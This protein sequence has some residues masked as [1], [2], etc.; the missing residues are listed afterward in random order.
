MKMR[1]LVAL[2]LAV[3]TLTTMS[4][5]GCSKGGSSSGA[6]K[7]VQTI[8]VLKPDDSVTNATYKKFMPNL[9]RN[10]QANI[11]QY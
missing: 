4:L 6:A 5:T 9:M 8:N 7:G 3:G 11:R 2:V 10:M 1:K